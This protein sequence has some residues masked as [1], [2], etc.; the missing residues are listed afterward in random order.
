MVEILRGTRKLSDAE[1]EAKRWALYEE[2]P[3]VEC[4][5]YC[6]RECKA[7]IPIFAGEAERLPQ[8]TTAQGQWCPF[9]DLQT[10]RCTVH[11][12]RPGICRLYGVTEGLPCRWGCKPDHWLSVAEGGRWIRRLEAV[13]QL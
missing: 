6:Y 9:L 2:L 3:S 10:K 12:I 8:F 5:G 1:K 4:K 13:E 11:Q 7:E